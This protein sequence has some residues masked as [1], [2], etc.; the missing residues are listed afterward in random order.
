MLYLPASLVAD[1]LRTVDPRWAFGLVTS[2]TLA[3]SG[4][5]TWVPPASEVSRSLDAIPTG[6]R[7]KHTKSRP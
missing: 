1:A 2:L 5:F 4:L 6:I 3:A 7:L